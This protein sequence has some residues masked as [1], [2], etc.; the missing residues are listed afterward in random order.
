MEGIKNMIIKGYLKGN[1]V[2]F[3]NKQG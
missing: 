2:Y 1:G 3:V